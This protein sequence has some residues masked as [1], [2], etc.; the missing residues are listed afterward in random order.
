MD[1]QIEGNGVSAHEAKPKTAAEATR[2]LEPD[3]QETEQVKGG[4]IAVLKT[5]LDNAT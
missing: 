1:N 5:G 3:E 4:I 2:D